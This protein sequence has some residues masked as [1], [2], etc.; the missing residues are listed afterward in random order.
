MLKIKNLS[1]YYCGDNNTVKAVDDVSL[2]I[3]DGEFFGLVGPSGCGKSTLGLSIMKLI[4]EPGKIING[5]VELEG[6]DIMALDAKGL[7]KARGS[8]I[9]MI[10]QDPLTCL[11]PV[12][13]IG[14]QIAE[15]LRAHLPLG[16][17]EA[18]V[19]TIELLRSVKLKDPETGLNS[20][21]HEMSGG[22]RQRVM[23]AMAISCGS[24]FL[25]ADEPTTA[26]DVTTQKG[27]MELLSAMN[28]ELGLSVLF[29]THNIGLVKKYCG[30]AA[31]M[32]NGK[33][34]FQGESSKLIERF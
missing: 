11:N 30:T 5:S 6:T 27:V 17:N 23:I 24:K 8:K 4:D 15:A 2:K 14:E 12:M 28:K 3:A 33:I 7:E 20:Y 18:R 26:L 32:K 19:R 34:T 21:P 10:F 25:I 9:S 29:I 31:V 22:M 1:T 13:R 16:Q